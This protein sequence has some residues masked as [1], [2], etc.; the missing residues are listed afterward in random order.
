MTGTKQ[1]IA[2]PTRTKVV[3]VVVLALAV[4]GFLVAGLRADTDHSD[5]VRVSGAPGQAVQDTE[6][7]LAVSP[8]DGTQALAQQPLSIRLA[9][10]WTGELTFLPGDGAATPLPQDEIEVTALNELVYQ[11]ADGKTLERL[12]EGTTSCVKATVWDQVRGRDATETTKTWCFSV[13]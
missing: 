7:V 1:S 8:G 4:A 12:P 13:T 2:Y 9:A 3:V 6:G 11:P 5:D 10:G